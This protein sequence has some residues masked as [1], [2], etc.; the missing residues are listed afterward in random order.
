VLPLPVLPLPVLPL[1]V[2]PEPEDVVGGDPAA[3]RPRLVARAERSVWS[4]VP[5]DSEIEPYWTALAMA[6][7][8]CWRSDAAWFG[9][10]AASSETACWAGA[11]MDLAVPEPRV[12]ASV[13]EAR[14][15]IRAARAAGALGTVV[16]TID[17]DVVVIDVDFGAVSG[18]RAVRGRDTW[19]DPVAL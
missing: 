18:L 11:E 7:A 9:L 5:S 8:A 10:P 4:V 19:V 16:V 12:P 3:L 17:V 15:R 6:C 2:F 13:A 1:P 14:S